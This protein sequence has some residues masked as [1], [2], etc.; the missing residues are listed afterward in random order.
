MLVP[1][2]RRFDW[3]KL[4]ALLGVTRMSL[5]D[6]DEAREVTGYERGTITPFGSERAWPV[7]ADASMMTQPLVSIGG[8]THGVTLQLTPADL[9]TGL[10][11][12]VADVSVV[13]EGDAADA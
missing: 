10:A 8:G 7:I 9:V 13:D 5:P 12:T 4:R 3:P 2:G 1:G 11:A 6:K